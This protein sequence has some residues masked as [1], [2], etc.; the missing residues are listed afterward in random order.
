[1]PDF[2]VADPQE[3]LFNLRDAE[4]K[5][6]SSIDAID[7]IEMV[8]SARDKSYE[9]GDPDNWFIYFSQSL[10][11]KSGV[12]LSKTQALM[13]IQEAEKCFVKL[14]KN[15]SKELEPQEPLEESPTSASETSPS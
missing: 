7:I 11:K 4:G 6:L 15:G 9:S 2:F 1:M 14:K 12:K 5:L 8:R 13:L 10:N 3:T